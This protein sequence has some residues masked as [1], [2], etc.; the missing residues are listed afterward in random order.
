MDMSTLK[1]H[2]R[3]TLKFA[4]LQ[5]PKFRSDRKTLVPKRAM[6]LQHVLK[7]E[8]SARFRRNV[9]VPCSIALVIASPLMTISTR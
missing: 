3:H 9:A 1:Q 7:F 8:P 5:D 6:L 2:L 4:H